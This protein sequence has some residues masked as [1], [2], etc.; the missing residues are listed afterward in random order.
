MT[1][2][3]HLNIVAESSKHMDDKNPVVEI[4]FKLIMQ[5][6]IIDTCTTVTRLR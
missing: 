1:E 2:T 5:K 3:V 4:L 6:S